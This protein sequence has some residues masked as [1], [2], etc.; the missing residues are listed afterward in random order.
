MLL[1][2]EDSPIYPLTSKLPIFKKFRKSL[3]ELLN[4]LITSATEL[5]LLYSSDLMTT[6]QSWIVSMSSSQLRS[7]RHTATVIALELQTALCDVAAAVEKE[8]EVVGR[9]REGERKR[10]AGG[11]HASAAR[12]KDLDAKAAEI[13]DR[14]TQL[15]EYLKEFVDG[16]VL[17][18]YPA[19]IVHN[20]FTVFLFTAI[21]TWI[22]TSVPSV[23]KQWGNGSRSIL[24]ISLTGNISATSAGCFLTQQ[25]QFGY[26]PYAHCQMLTLA[27]TI[28]AHFHILRSAFGHDSLRWHAAT[29]S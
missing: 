2:Q 5:G 12:E 25:H 6:L 11:K 27:L 28:S 15:A 17:V 9:Q 20:V 8:A 21:A 29:W 22:L 13:R 10:K 14:R 26:R 16:Y 7:F 1:S 24:H 23:F 19:N 4:R 18:L 3:S